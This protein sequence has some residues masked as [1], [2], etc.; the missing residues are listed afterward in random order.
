[1]SRDLVSEWNASQAV[2]AAKR[3][4]AAAM[5]KNVFIAGRKLILHTNIAN[6]SEKRGFSLFL[7]DDK[8]P[9]RTGTDETVRRCRGLRGLGPE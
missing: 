4:A 6:F 5:R 3:A 8:F 2:I 9:A 1:M 7:Q